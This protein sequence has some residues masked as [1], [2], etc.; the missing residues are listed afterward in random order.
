VADALQALGQSVIVKALVPTGRRGKVGA[1]QRAVG[2]LEAK[3]KA[4]GILG[5]RVHG[6]VV[7]KVL[8][9]RAIK[10]AQEL[11]LAFTFGPAGVRVLACRIGGVDVEET[12]LRHPE[13]V[14]EHAVDHITGLRRYH[15]IDL[16]QKA[17]ASSLPLVKLADFTVRLWEAFR[18]LDAL[19][20]EINPLAVDE[21][22]SLWAVGTMLSV[23]DAAIFRHPELMS[24]LGGGGPEWREP[25]I[26]E[27]AVAIADRNLTGGRVRYIE[28]DGEIGLFV[29]GGGAGLMIHDLLVTFGGK[30]AN[31]TDVTPGRTPDKLGVVF[32][33]ILTH[34]RVTSLLVCVNHLQMARADVIVHAL[35]DS[36][37]KHRID[38]RRFPIVVR[39][40]GPGEDDARALAAE[41]PGIRYLPR[42]ASIEEAVRLIIDLPAHA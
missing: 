36:L 15:S 3:Q 26:R 12:R 31:H 18:S 40:F 32:D 23:D 19:M 25:T 29:A 20:L 9:E 5:S 30:P 1:V 2:V 41:V 24:V 13:I 11:Y 28:L 7:E 22:G 6:Y 17:G 33:A 37:R 4:D 27:R 42:G 8:V 34:P 10:I 21:H 14:I 38:A 39:V 16:W 35:V